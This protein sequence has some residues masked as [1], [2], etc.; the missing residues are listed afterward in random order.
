MPLSAPKVVPFAYKYPFSSITSML[1]FA[2]SKF[3]FSS[4]SHTISVCACSIIGILLQFFFLIKTLL[5]LSFSYSKFLASANSHKYS[6]IFPSF[7]DSLGILAISL[8]KLIV[9]F[10]LN[11]IFP[12]NLLI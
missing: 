2:K 7:P 9:L 4:F 12:S 10:V 8:K 1:S 11:S 5:Y 6:A 3:L